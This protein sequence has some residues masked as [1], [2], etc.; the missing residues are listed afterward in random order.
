MPMPADRVPE[1]AREATAANCSIRVISGP[2]A[3]RVMPMVRDE[4]SVGRVGTQVAHI[5]RREGRY[6]LS[7][8][9]GVA[10][11]ILNGTAIPEEGA[12][13]GPGDHFMVAGIEL[14]FEQQ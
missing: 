9:E 3:G 6:R 7:R 11:V 10:P 4:F 1:Q 12:Q 5:V 13:I 2:S 14:A 8:I